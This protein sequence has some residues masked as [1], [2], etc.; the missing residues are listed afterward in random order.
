MTTCG[1]LLLYPLD[2]A[3]ANLGVD[4]RTPIVTCAISFPTS[5]R[6]EP[7]EYQVNEVYRKLNL[8][9]LEEPEGD[10]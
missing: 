3:H 9:Q 4:Q 5:E 1:L 2:A 6:A 7:V 8:E 10:A